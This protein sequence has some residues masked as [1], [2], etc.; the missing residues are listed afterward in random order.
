MSCP[1]SHWWTFTSRCHERSEQAT[2][3]KLKTWA[4][5]SPRKLWNCPQK[6]G[7][8]A[9]SSLAHPEGNHCYE[10]VGHISP[11][12]L[13]L[14]KVLAYVF[15]KDELLTT[16]NLQIIWFFLHHHFCMPFTCGKIYFLTFFPASPISPF[17]P[18]FPGNPGRPISP[19]KKKKL[20]C[21][22]I[23]INCFFCKMDP[24][25]CKNIN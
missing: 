5:C 14:A 1:K 8:L 6:S 10:F 7:L 17:N 15:L 2:T 23:S 11:S 24:T 18:F 3:N 13:S 20:L 25:F 21:L 12:P 16:A 9:C 4:T 22:H 19:L